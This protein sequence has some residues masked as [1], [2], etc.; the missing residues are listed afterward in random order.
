MSATLPLAYETA[1]A[2]MGGG[3]RI[4]VVAFLRTRLALDAKFP[5]SA[6]R[7][8]TTRQRAREPKTNKQRENDTTKH[9]ETPPRAAPDAR[10]HR[11]ELERTQPNNRPQRPKLSVMGLSV[12]PQYAFGRVDPRASGMS[13]PTR[14]RDVPGD[15]LHALLDAASHR[16]RPLS[17]R[18][19]PIASRDENMNEQREA[20]AAECIFFAGTFCEL[21][22]SIST[23]EAKLARW[24]AY[25]TIP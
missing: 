16:I 25:V 3:R 21:H 11:L 15:A 9:A 13:R 4:R 18:R 12:A 7:R 17:I 20:D 24:F 10:L 19:R 23:E 5:P 6:E 2:S 8:P 14:R 1:V 22:S